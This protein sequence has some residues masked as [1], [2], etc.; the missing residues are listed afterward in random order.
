MK[1]WKSNYGLA[2]AR[3][4]ALFIF[5]VLVS[6]ISVFPA[7]VAQYNFDGNANDS[8]S[9]NHGTVSGPVSTND[10]LGNANA[11]YYFDGVDD[12]ISVPDADHLDCTNFT[13]TIWAKPSVNLSGNRFFF[14]KG[15]NFSLRFNGS[16]DFIVNNIL[17][18]DY[19]TA[20]NSNTWYHLA[21]TFDAG[22]HVQKGYI[23]GQV[24]HS[25]NLTHTPILTTNNLL[26][27]ALYETGGYNIPGIL[28]DV[29]IYNHALSPAEIS[30]ISEAGYLVTYDKNA[31]DAAGTMNAQ[32]VFS[33]GILSKNIFTRTGYS[34]TGWSLSS[35]GPVHYANGGRF[36]NSS[37][38]TLYAVWGSKNLLAN[39]DWE[40]GSTN[41]W[42]MTSADGTG[43]ALISGVGWSG[44]K[45]A[46]SS[47]Q[48]CYKSQRV[49]A[50]AHGYSS[51]LLS[52]TNTVIT[53]SEWV[54]AYN[55][56][57]AAD[58]YAVTLKLLDNS[59]SIVA[60]VT[61]GTK[62]IVPNDGWVQATVSFTNTAG[63]TNIVYFEVESMGDDGESW[64]GFY[65]TIFDDATLSV[66]A[67]LTGAGTAA[68]PYLIGSLDTLRLVS[69]MT[70][71]WSNY[72]RLTAHI[73]A[74]PTS[75]WNGGEG[76]IPIGNLTT[77]FTGFFDG[78][79][80][81]IS[82]L[83][84]NRSSEYYQGLFGW[85][86]G[87][88]VVSNL[89]LLNAVVTGGE[90]VGALAGK[91]ENSTIHSVYN[92]GRVSG[93]QYIGGYTG[94]TTTVNFFQCAFAGTV[95]NSASMYSA[96]FS[97]SLDSSSK[98]FDSY[99][100]GTLVSAGN[101]TG[102]F[103]GNN[104]SGSLVSNCY[105]SGV[106]ICTQANAGALAG[107]SSSGSTL[108]SF[109]NT[110]LTAN[111]F[112]AS[113]PATNGCLGLNTAALQSQGSFPLFD[114]TSV[115]AIDPLKKTNEGYPFLRAHAFSLVSNIPAGTNVP[116]DTNAPAVAFSHSTMTTNQPFILS[117]SVN[118]NYGYYSLNGTV[119][120]TFTTAGTNLTISANTTVYGYGLDAAS[121]RS[122]TITNVYTVSSLSGISIGSGWNFISIPHNVAESAETMFGSALSSLKGFYIYGWD[123]EY[124]YFE[125]TKILQPGQG[126]F[127]AV[128]D[129]GS[130][131]AVIDS[132]KLLGSG[133]SH[134]F[135]I[136]KSGWHLFGNPFLHGFSTADVTVASGGTTKTFTEAVAAGWLEGS[137]W[138]WVNGYVN[139]PQIPAGSAFWLK[140]AVNGLTVTLNSVAAQ[141]AAPYLR[142]YGHALSPVFENQGTGI[143][144]NFVFARE[145][146]VKTADT[147]DSGII[148]AAAAA[149]LDGID[150][151][152]ITKA[153]AIAD[154]VRLSV[155]DHGL[156][157]DF[158]ASD[159]KTKR[160]VLHIDHLVT[161][162]ETQLVFTSLTG[163]GYYV[164]LL[165]DNESGK[166][167]QLG[168]AGSYSFVPAVDGRKSFVAYA[169]DPAT[170]Q[171]MIGGYSVT[172]VIA[173]P[174]PARRYATI[175]LELAAPVID[176]AVFQI[177]TIAGRLVTE[178]RFINASANRLEWNWNLT[179][180]DGSRISEG[181]Y[182]I[183][184][185][186]RLDDGSLK[187][188]S[189]RIYIE[190]PE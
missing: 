70:N 77:K 3:K 81:S 2:V 35:G 176:D 115:W 92:S 111:G 137:A 5:M 73:D 22:T 23:N 108:H 118:E 145:V 52:M 69:V 155:G 170:A 62:T 117:L 184:T 50:E 173:Y 68:S 59:F 102:G 96:F 56:N 95:S 55:G 16:L 120:Y 78:N 183:K 106:M 110:D 41:G 157:G 38:L 146:M 14:S 171:A 180:A 179:A 127:V 33:N 90:Y 138:R 18:V 11:A 130:A 17:C 121:N 79:G 53:F 40:N 12:Y 86:N 25:S 19:A 6:V 75:G 109:W 43:Y 119:F 128:P 26:I 88:A 175:A 152:D 30:N 132:A 150:V 44:S 147:A 15:N 1:R 93:S 107:W 172:K 34:F 71:V 67:G 116:A 65:G 166:L 104:Y 141:A 133:T 112:G 20:L 80:F 123:T 10:R 36:T 63:L 64:A 61:T 160:F 190:K 182:I 187:E 74:T 31:A 164:W 4:T 134:A 32:T 100:R 8:S 48:A 136:S 113:S 144:K 149:A 45:G 66:T 129:G 135:S 122:P 42:T 185:K 91:M 140:T 189:G 39:N 126:Y 105:V 162:Q 27:G 174:N 51:A 98:I 9:N 153:P 46:V 21:V 82:N 143:G 101:Y 178:G 24:I 168:T 177:F 83:Y 87:G 60:S 7:L 49:T 99:C 142:T 37:A 94:I 165:Q 13:L 84:I 103:A 181:L 148:L 163:E 151:Y 72:F 124:N 57:A 89:S 139:T 188:Q 159:G 29:K 76:F 54:A 154:T 169:A 167:T 28:D 186:F 58:S 125:E 85:I 114:F 131:S 156:G 158:R 47:H 97:G 161:G